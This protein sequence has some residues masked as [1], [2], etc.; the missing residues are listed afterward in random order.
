VL[1][2]PRAAAALLRPPASHT[3]RPHWLPHGAQHAHHPPAEQ[4]RR[5]SYA[6][7]LAL[8][9]Q[10]WDAWERS[11]AGAHSRIDGRDGSLEAKLD[12]LTVAVQQLLDGER[13]PLPKR[14]SWSLPV[15]TIVS[16]AD[17]VAAAPDLRRVAPTA[18][19]IVR[20]VQNID[21]DLG[22]RRG[23]LASEYRRTAWQSAAA[24]GRGMLLQRKGAS[25]DSPLIF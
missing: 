4:A 18:V 11:K 7:A 2:S 21:R 10:T 3:T 19:S 14:Q 1:S 5:E 17:T 25:M 13:Q 12:V 8:D 9:G 16:L 22:T 23:M 15:E 6:E 20:R 24:L